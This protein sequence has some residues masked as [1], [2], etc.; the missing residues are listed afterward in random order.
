MA[1]IVIVVVFLGVLYGASLNPLNAAPRINEQSG[2]YLRSRWKDEYRLF[3]VDSQLYYGVYAQN[4]TL[5]H[6]QVLYSVQAGDPCIIIN[7]TIRN[8]YG[9]KYHFKLGVNVWNTDG[10][11]VGPILVQGEHNPGEISVYMEK[12]STIVFDLRIPYDA[13]DITAY[14]LVILYPYITPIP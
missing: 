7:G 13:T 1:V 3:L 11:N 8:D 6:P 2:T 14:E 4:F 10:E 12:D 9:F 5:F